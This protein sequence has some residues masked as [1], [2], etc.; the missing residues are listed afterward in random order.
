MYQL[1]KPFDY[2]QKG[3]HIIVG[4]ETFQRCAFS[5]PTAIGMNEHYGEL[6]SIKFRE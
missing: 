2:P 1:V 4:N 6:N 3:N 5:L